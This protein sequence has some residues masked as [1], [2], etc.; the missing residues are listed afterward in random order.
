MEQIRELQAFLDEEKEKLEDR[1]YLFV[2]NQILKISKEVN[3][4]YIEAE[5]KMSEANDIQEA[6]DLIYAYC[7]LQEHK[8]D[9]KIKALEY[10]LK[11]K[12]TLLEKAS[13]SLNDTGTHDPN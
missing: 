4:V 9:E 8:K 5:Q 2:C 10:F 6:T 13:R 3:K 1:I 11:E 12:E 7:K